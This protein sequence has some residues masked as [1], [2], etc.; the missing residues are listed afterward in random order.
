MVA[1]RETGHTCR[2]HT[3]SV[4]ARGMSDRPAVV[5]SGAK[6]RRRRS[7]FS[8]TEKHP[9]EAGRVY[10]IL[11]AKVGEVAGVVFGKGRLEGNWGS[12][13]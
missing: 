1:E 3:V 6:V 4:F 9:R 5:G 2:A 13:E 12:R 10:K 7:R 11:V 8:I